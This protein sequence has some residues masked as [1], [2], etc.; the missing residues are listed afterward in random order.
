MK[1]S[2][3]FLQGWDHHTATVH[4]YIPYDRV[5]NFKDGQTC[6][7]GSLVDWN[8]KECIRREEKKRAYI[9]SFIEQVWYECAYGLEDFWNDSDHPHSKKRGC[10]AKF[11]ITQLQ[12]HPDVA[13]IC[14]YYVGHI[15]EDGSHAHGLH[16]MDSI[17]RKTTH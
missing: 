10:I 15:R 4:A 14:Y 8:V 11:Y 17:G 13:E 3:G 6:E 7:D 2:H 9:T 5:S 12:L 16:N 1:I